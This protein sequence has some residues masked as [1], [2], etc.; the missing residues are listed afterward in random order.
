MPQP[1][2][3][4]QPPL[5]FI[6]PQYNPLVVK[7]AQILV[8][9]LA[10]HW[11]SLT[12]IKATN[13]E[14]LAE[15]YQQFQAGN[16]RLMLAFRHPSTDDPFAMAELLYRLVP[17]AARHQRIPLR[18]PVHGHF[19]YDRGIPLWAG[20]WMGWL[21]SRMGGIPILRG[22]VDRLGLRTVRDLFANGQFPIVAA[23]EG[24]TNGHNEI[25]SPLEP[26][27]AQLCFWCVEDLHKAGRNQPVLLVPI[28]IQYR[29]VQAP[30]EK[31][32]MLMGQLETA[33]GL[34][35]LSVD[36]AES[37]SGLEQSLAQFYPDN[38]REKQLYLRLYRLGEQ[39]LGVM[40]QF[41]SRYY[42]HNLAAPASITPT[43]ATALTSN[44]QLALRLQSL[45]NTALRVAEQYFN[46]TP[47]GT[48][49][50]RCRRL[51]Q[52]GWDLIYREDIEDLEKLSPVERSLADFIAQESSLRMW[53]MRMVESF[54]SVTGKYVLEKP[55]AERFA[56]TTLLMW[57]LITRIQG[58]NP[59]SRPQLG[60]RQVYM[61]VGQ[62]I[63]V[64]DR[65]HSYQSS[66]RSAK[67]AVT[68]L[69]HDLQAALEQM[70]V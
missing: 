70:I 45:L 48:V 29:Y 67:Q 54:V 57:D 69:T 37:L 11:R 33:V 24:A 1:I 44:E 49:A 5:A 21:Y 4:V 26:G 10:R 17:Q 42:H 50:D 6:P 62:P 30:W 41:Y 46:L 51:E 2:T 58:G 19:I 47:K 31:L 28:G 40:E 12:R 8:P 53:H 25:I 43:P 7:A 32:S 55:T 39:M 23:P 68:D 59:F 35:Q 3:Q 60:Q 36:Q 22:K 64:S 13:V 14:K 65:W 27:I 63:C 56:E 61:T 9:I 20:N 38:G 66:R 18:S 15:L 16:V 52:A 34:P